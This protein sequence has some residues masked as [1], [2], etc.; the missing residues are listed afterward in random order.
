MTMHL[1][2]V[3]DAEADEAAVMRTRE[4]ALLTEF[5]WSGPPPSGF[6]QTH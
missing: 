1:D 4:L 6:R 5:H 2:R 3:H